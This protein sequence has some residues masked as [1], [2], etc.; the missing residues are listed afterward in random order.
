MSSLDW[1]VK[2]DRFNNYLQKTC[3]V[4]GF[5]CLVLSCENRADYSEIN[6][7]DPIGQLESTYLKDLDACL[8][9]IEQMK[10]E[11]DLDT[12]QTFYHQA[13]AKFKEME[14]VLSF[15]DINNY[16][17]LNAPNILKVEEEDQTDIKIR[18]AKSFQSLEEEIYADQPDLERIHSAAEFI[19][20]RLEL[21][22]ITTDLSHYK[23]YHIL[24]LVR[25]QLVRTATTGVTGFDS[26]VLEN[27]LEDAV[28][29]FAKAEYY[30]FLYEDKFQHPALKDSWRRAFTAAVNDLK[31]TDFDSFDR[32]EFIQQHIDPMLAIWN[33]TAA[34]WEIQFPLELAM[35]NEATH[36]FGK[37]SL[38][39][40]YF[41]DHQVGQLKKEQVNLGRMLFNDTSLSADGSMSCAS[42]HVADLAFSDGKKTPKGL[43]RNS[44]GLTYAAYQRG[45]FYDKR[46][47]SLEGQIISVIENE[48]EFHSDLR[49]FVG[50]IAN[51]QKY[52]QAFA[53]SYKSKI[54][55]RSVRRAI[56]DYVRSLTDWDSRF[57]LSI[58]GEIDDLTQA[59]INGFN[60]FMGKAK[61][62][63]CHFAP[64]FNGTVPPDYLDTEIEHLGVPEKADWENAIIDSDP[65]RYTVFK[66]SSRKH[67]FKTPSIRNIALTAPYMHNGVYQTLE[68]VVK[69]YNLGGGYGIGITDQEF[70]TLPP[71]PLDLTEKEQSDLISFMKSLTDARYNSHT[72]INPK[73]L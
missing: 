26:P 22:K 41:A 73:A 63:T 4:A 70:Q 67:F 65:G 34:D 8:A 72:S 7:V 46:S 66:T 61:C 56:A 27:S 53:N 43:D 18:E 10:G 29:A 15:H 23:P 6:V 59:E 33:E 42:C 51:E 55:E 54:D 58:R 37:E 47:G 1:I 21:I 3:L 48:K 57:D 9:I 36:L 14:P 12:L 71:D 50:S 62:A 31:S 16:A 39:P 40:D 44:P 45:F 68:E 60:L 17:S 49:Q 38:S 2:M 20:S 35:S 30:L 13:R 64:V 5:L 69:F 32:Y 19:A 11:E 25:K 28:L 52:V 24:W